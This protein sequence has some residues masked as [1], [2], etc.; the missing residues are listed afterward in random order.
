M[1]N[2]TEQELTWQDAA[3]AAKEA[4]GILNALPEFIEKFQKLWVMLGITAEVPSGQQ[5]AIWYRLHE[6]DL[7]VLMVALQKTSHKASAMESENKKFTLDHS[8]RFLS[9]VANSL[10]TLKENDM[11]TETTNTQ[12]APQTPATGCLGRI[13]LKEEPATD[14]KTHALIPDSTEVKQ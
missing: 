8:V 1:E 13:G 10:K 5:V 11:K 6:S 7:M 2:Q 3:H 9:S 14:P 12:K 4:L